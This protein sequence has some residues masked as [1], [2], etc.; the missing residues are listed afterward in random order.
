MNLDKQ[1]EIKTFASSE[2][3]TALV[4]DEPVCGKIFGRITCTGR[5]KIIFTSEGAIQWK[6]PVCG[7]EGIITGEKDSL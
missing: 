1:K 7:D 4:A 3:S 2:Q 5:L 6:C